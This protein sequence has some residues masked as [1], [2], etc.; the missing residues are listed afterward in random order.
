MNSNGFNCNPWKIIL[1][2]ILHC[3]LSCSRV[4]TSFHWSAWRGTAGS[5]RRKLAHW[6]DIIR[7]T[8]VH[9]FSLKTVNM[10]IWPKRL[11]YQRFLPLNFF[12]TSLFLEIG[13][14]KDAERL[15]TPNWMLRAVIFLLLSASLNFNLSSSATNSVI[16]KSSS[17]LKRCWMQLSKGQI[18]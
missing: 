1:G 18:S 16:I 8:K 3:V 14:V 2:Q 11:Q 7:S 5:W 12:D 4:S 13:D 15:V 17:L 6:W 9:V 10:H